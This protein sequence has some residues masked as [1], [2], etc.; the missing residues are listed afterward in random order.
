MEVER[1]EDGLW[2]WRTV[3]PEWKAGGGWEA[4]VGCVYW[5]G[6]DAIVLVDPLLPSEDADRERFL[7][8]LDRD[9]ERVGK[10]VV[11][12]TTVSWHARS[13]GAIAERYAGRVIEPSTIANDHLPAGV[14]SIATTAEGEHVYWL[15]GARA[16]VPG[17]VLIGNPNGGVMVSPVSWFDSPEVAQAVRVQLLAVLDLPVER[18]LVSHG[19]PVLTDGLEALRE[20]LAHASA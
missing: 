1:I 20:A 2:L 9:V 17:D 10:P 7:E 3:H 16:L 8:A 13:G 12:L 18:V 15:E 4:T 5:E 6:P 11:V 14:H 19:E